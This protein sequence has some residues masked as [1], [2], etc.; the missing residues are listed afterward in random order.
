MGMV[1]TRFERIFTFWVGRAVERK[2]N[3]VQEGHTGFS[4]LLV[5][6][7]FMVWVVGT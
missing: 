1:N 2:R 4:P 6:F 7:Y 3:G 5:K